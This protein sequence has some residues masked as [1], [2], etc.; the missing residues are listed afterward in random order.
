MKIQLFQ[1]TISE[2]RRVFQAI[3]FYL[4]FCIIMDFRPSDTLKQPCLL[5]IS[6]IHKL[7]LIF[8]PLQKYGISYSPRVFDSF[9]GEQFQKPQALVLQISML[10]W[11]LAGRQE[12]YPIVQ[13]IG[14]TEQIK[15]PLKTV[16][17]FLLIF[18]VHAILTNSS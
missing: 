12:K 17:S 9:T 15:P 11:N 6:R 16:H 13:I 2:T 1:E 18:P 8:A 10:G 7:I 5:S 4:L 14:G 3:L